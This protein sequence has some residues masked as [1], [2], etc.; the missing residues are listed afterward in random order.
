[1]ITVTFNILSCAYNVELLIIYF[2]KNVNNSTQFL[3]FYT[4]LLNI[5]CLECHCDGCVKIKFNDN[6]IAHEKQF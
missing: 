3:L 5:M 2:F 1:M 6:I 4:I